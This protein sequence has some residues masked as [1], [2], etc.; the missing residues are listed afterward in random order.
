M[1][2]SAYFEKWFY[3]MKSGN[4]RQFSRKERLKY[5]L[6]PLIFILKTHLYDSN[7]LPKYGVS[8]KTLSQS[9]FLA[10]LPAYIVRECVQS[11]GS[12]CNSSKPILVW[13]FQHCK[14]NTNDTNY[15]SNVE[16]FCVMLSKKISCNSFASAQACRGSWFKNTYSNSYCGNR[17]FYII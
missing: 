14:S 6:T 2:P 15:Q 8:N 10:T 1:Q 7:S 9:C 4:T 16:Q 17:D 12:G 5:L 13:N 11:Q 3:S